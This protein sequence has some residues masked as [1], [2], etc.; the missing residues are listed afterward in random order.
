M[1]VMRVAKTTPSAN[2]GTQYKCIGASANRPTPLVEFQVGLLTGG[3]DRPYAFGLAMA[4]VSKRVGLDLIG[5]DEL[6]SPELQASPNLRFLNLR[7]NQRRDASLATKMWRILI[8]YARLIRYASV[9]KPKIF[10]ILWNNKFQ[11]FDR[12][13]LML[14]YRLL[15]KKIAFTAHNVN[16]GKRDSNDSFLNRLTL[17]IQYRLADHIFV[18]TQ[19]MKS[20]LLSDFD[21]CEAAVTVIPFGINNSVPH[22]DL[23]FVEAKQTLGIGDRDKT[24]L[25][26]GNIEPYK[27]LQFLIAAFQRLSVKNSDYRLIIAGRLGRGCEKYWDEIQ[28]TISR[29]TSGGRVIHK[30]GYVPDE[31]AELYFKAAD[32]LVLPYTHVFQSGVLFLGYSFGLP[33][34][35][36]D[37]GSLREDIIEGRTGFLCKPRDPIDLARSIEGYF[38]SD[39]FRNLDSRRQEIRDYANARNSWD[40]VGRMTLNVYAEL[41]A[42]PLSQGRGLM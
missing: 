4:L 28:R 6:C 36:A 16:A 12:T 23:T 38:E 15:G 25:F 22:T 37:V 24:I 3:C 1:K 39:L 9:A 17:R 29:D 19:K 5:S 35:A 21:V 31:H 18:H 26:F 41:L 10:H 32:I 14:Y 40:V 20:E 11:M 27:G 7:G 33:A 13:L 8:Y 30:I 2:T 34:V 42:S